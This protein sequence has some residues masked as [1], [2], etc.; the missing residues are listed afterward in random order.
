MS[1]GGQTAV[2][3][4]WQEAAGQTQPQAQPAQQPVDPWQEAAKQG[5]PQ[6]QQPPAG[7]QPPGAKAQSLLEGASHFIKDIYADSP[8]VR[9]MTPGSYQARKGGPI[10]NANQ[11]AAHLAIRQVGK[12]MGI[13]RE[14][15]S[16]YDGF[17]Q[18]GTSLKDFILDSFNTWN[19]GLKVG[20]A[21]QP[22]QAVAPLAAAVMTPIEMT[23]RAAESI[24]GGFESGARDVWTGVQRRDPRSVAAGVGEVGGSALSTE[25]ARLGEGALEKPSAERMPIMGK[26]AKEQLGR[27]AQR[28]LQK[29]AESAQ[30]NLATAKANVGTRIGALVN[31]ISDAD[32]LNSAGKGNIGSIKSAPVLEAYNNGIEKFGASFVAGS[33]L[34]NVHELLAKATPEM[35]WET[36]KDLRSRIGAEMYKLPEGSKA[37]GVVGEAYGQLTKQLGDRAE[38]LNQF[39]QFKAYNDLHENMMDYIHEGI[40]GKLFGIDKGLDFFD[41]LRKPSNKPLLE[42]LEKDLGGE[43]GLEKDFFDNMVNSH[44]AT[45][46]LAK[47]MESPGAGMMGKFRALGAHP[48]AAGAAAVA[49]G[50][51]P[52]PIP[53]IG[54]FIISMFAAAKAADIADRVQAANEMRARG[55]P[56]ITGKFGEAAGVT[57]QV[58]VRGPKIRVVQA[59]PAPSPAAPS[60]EQLKSQVKQGGLTPEEMDEADERLAEEE[61]KELRAKL[62]GKRKD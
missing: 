14:P 28:T 49:T 16:L 42:D 2:T 53:G 60:T 29:S 33:G 12:S 7:K 9:E 19:T 57:P 11:T 43:F 54:K 30:Q 37:R 39:S 4:P 61:A 41:A 40:L 21:G 52:I 44:K 1:N 31:S 24:A 22:S 8:E 56:E 50:A 35:P 55:V 25:I 5:T 6:Q 23:A 18:V 38:Q 34:A 51:L 26:A 48:K 58:G 46:R 15:T 32:L 20:L 36:A 13:G 10:L 17:H 3:D 47:S 62:K 59:P 27:A 45:Y